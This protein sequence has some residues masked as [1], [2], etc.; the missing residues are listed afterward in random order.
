MPTADVVKFVESRRTLYPQM[1]E[2]IFDMMENSSNAAVEAI[3]RGDWAT[4]GTIMNFCHGLMDAMGVSNHAL[5]SIVYALR[6][7]PG[8]LGS[9][10][11]GSGLGDCAVGLGTV[12]RKDFPYAVMPVKIAAQGVDIEAA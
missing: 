2:N 4:V 9:K 7:E 3:A 11:S 8:I 1:F 12:T 6:A 10:I 5:S